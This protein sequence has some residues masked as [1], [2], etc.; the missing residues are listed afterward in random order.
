[1]QPIGASQM[2]NNIEV[3]RC[4]VSVL[5][6]YISNCLRPPRHRALNRSPRT[7]FGYPGRLWGSLLGTPGLPLGAVLVPLDPVWAPLGAPWL[8][9]DPFWAPRNSLWTPSI[10]QVCF[11]TQHVGSLAARLCQNPIIYDILL[12]SQSSASYASFYTAHILKDVSTSK[13]EFWVPRK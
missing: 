3:R 10:S 2:Q 6:I 8:P 11:G 9:L 13:L 12:K 1:M 4:R 5:N 7:L